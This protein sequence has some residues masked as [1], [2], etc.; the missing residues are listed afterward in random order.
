MPTFESTGPRKPIAVVGFSARS[1]AFCARRA[2]F[3]PVAVDFCSDRDLI[4]L[5]TQHFKFDTSDSIGHLHL[6]V[7]HVPTLLTGGMEHRLSMVEELVRTGMITGCD[8]TQMKQMRSASNWSRWAANCGID[9]PTTWFPT[10]D[11]DL[12]HENLKTG[13]WLVKPQLGVGGL[14]IQNW[15][16]TIQGDGSN[17]VR[18][19]PAAYVQKKVDGDSV[20]VTFLSSEH[21]TALLGAAMSIGQDTQGFMPR[22]TYRG[23]CGPIVLTNRPDSKTSIICGTCWSGNRVRWAMA[24]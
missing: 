14:G 13:E 2:G 16:A 23:S 10:E 6:A 11:F 4:A 8:S 1:A 7:G 18:D 9:W 5:C 21:G 20:G 19:F 3:S 15:N 24:S 22:Y 17:F 12:L